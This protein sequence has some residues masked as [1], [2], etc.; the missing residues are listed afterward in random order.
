VRRVIRIGAGQG[1]CG[2]WFQRHP[3]AKEL[4]VPLTSVRPLAQMGLHAVELLHKRILGEPAESIILAPELQVRASLR[5]CVAPTDRP[6]ATSV[7]AILK[8]GHWQAR[9]TSAQTRHRQCLEPAS[10]ERTQS[11]IGVVIG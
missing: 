6:V 10:T 7:K 9:K 1:H 2:G 4:F 3:L 11:P 8:R 5:G